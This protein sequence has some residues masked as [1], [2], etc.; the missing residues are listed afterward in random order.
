MFLGDIAN[1]DPHPSECVDLLREY[2]PICIMGNHDRKITHEAEK[3][4][5][6]DEWSREKLND[7]QIKWIAG[8]EEKIIFEKRYNPNE[9]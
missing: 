9:N 6:W 5:F 3:R 2:S 4:N 1:F 8:F 7:E